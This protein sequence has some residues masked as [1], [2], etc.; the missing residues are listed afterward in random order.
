LPQRPLR[1]SSRLHSK[2]LLAAVAALFGAQAPAQTP[3]L[4]A[5]QPRA[6]VQAAAT[7]ELHIID[8]DGHAPLRY[9][10][11]KI[12]T[13]TDTT[14]LILE[15]RQGDVARLIE[16]NGQPITAAE[17]AAERA[18]LNAILRSPSDF[19]K[20]H[21]RD[22]STRADVLQVVSLM[23]QA[24]IYT[25]VPGQPQPQSATSP[26]VVID[27]RPDPAFHPPTMFADLLTGLEGRMWIDAAT[28]HLTRIEGHVLKPVD[29]GF[30][31]VARIAP[32]GTIELEQ[33]NAGSDRW[34]YSHLVENLSIRAMLVK[35]I[36]ENTRMTAT[37]FH[38]LPAPITFQEAVHQLLSA[39]IPLR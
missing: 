21:K 3:A 20:H 5:G 8:D 9:R 6:W 11:R 23:P 24:M 29:F 28:H 38:L 7:N 35:T 10:V 27:F 37:D 18:R 36:P 34:V 33:T 17:D 1:A 39:P 31:I 14:R 12:D 13:R 30:G 16:R 2:F 32:G 25:Y 26:Q 22:N 15:T 4:P 19:I